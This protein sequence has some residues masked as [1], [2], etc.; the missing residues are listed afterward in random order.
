M[1]TVQLAPLLIF[2]ICIIWNQPGFSKHVI[3][4]CAE[5]RICGDNGRCH[6]K[7]N[8]HYC[9]CIRGK[10]SAKNIK[11]C[12]VLDCLS[13]QKD[14]IPKECSSMKLEKG[15]NRK[16]PKNEKNKHFYCSIFN[17]A[18]DVNENCHKYKEKSNVSRELSLEKFTH[19]VNGMIQNISEWKKMGKGERQEAVMLLMDSM[20]SIVMVAA[21][22]MSNET[23]NLTTDNLDLQVQ[24]LQNDKIKT[25]GTV[26]LLAK[27]NEMDFYWETKMSDF[28]A[29]SLLAYKQM[30]SILDVDDLEMENKK[31]GKEYLQLNSD[32]LTATINSNN[33]TLQNVT[34]IIKNHEVDDVEDYT[35]CVHWRETENRKFWSTSGCRKVASNWT[36]T[37]CN[38]RHLSNFAVLVA[39]YK[40]ESPALTTITYIGIITSL[41]C[42]FTAII[43]F[44]VC[45]GIQS[46]RTTIHTHLCLCL[47]VAELLFLVGLSAT[48]NMSV[49]RAIAGFLHYLFLVCFMWM[50]LEGVQLYLMVVKV[51]LTQSLRGKYTYPVAYAIPA[52]FVIISAAANP[53]GYGT[54]E[55]CWLT[56]DKGFRWSFVGPLCVIC[57]VN[58]VFLILTIWKLAQKFY[59]INPDLP[60][61]QKI[62]MFI[63][64]AVAQL[65]LLGCTW[66]FGV[67]HFQARTIALAYI[68]TIINSF[69]G[70][71]IFILHCIINK[72]VRDEYRKWIARL[73]SVIKIPKYSTFSESTRPSSSTQVGVSQASVSHI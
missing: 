12:I 16:Q 18:S 58:L 8:G 70:T 26:T 9:V 43:T 23:F 3:D 48:R 5:D 24:I 41:V 73:F 47:F 37:T 33:K 61:L 42:L 64:T 62:R 2:Y 14:M 56:M 45:R 52:L 72:Q 34:F 35:V 39:L 54:R 38:C 6:P 7:E 68:F 21:A 11:P 53:K 19:T 44:I 51:F 49:C 1:K 40:V 46:T 67:F 57:L 10:E 60:H 59:T 36:H 32:M 28:A 29:V 27:G 50:L 65:V 31:Y 13:E 4:Y 66:V 30:E 69:Q 15:N 22:S 25:N 63:V 71:F 17:M 55:Y 20:E